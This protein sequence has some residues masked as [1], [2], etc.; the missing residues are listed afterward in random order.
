M[1][2]K[3]QQICDD[4]PAFALDYTIFLMHVNGLNWGCCEAINPCIGKTRYGHVHISQRFES[5]KRVQREEN[6]NRPTPIWH[7]ITHV[8]CTVYGFICS[9]CSSET[10]P[11]A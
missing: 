9:S 2:L 7:E 11:Q 5:L 4:I 3:C 1:V 8:H 6:R 10:S